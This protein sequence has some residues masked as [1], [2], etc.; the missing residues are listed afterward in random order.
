MT[1][2]MNID[3]TNNEIDEFG[4]TDLMLTADIEVVKMLVGKGCDM[5]VK[6]ESFNTALILSSSYI[7]DNISLFLIESGC[8]VNVQNNEGK[9]ALM[10]FT[11]RCSVNV[12]KALIARGCDVNMKDN[13]G[14]TAKIICLETRKDPMAALEGIMLVPGYEKFEKEYIKRFV[15][16]NDEI[17]HI[18]KAATK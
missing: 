14:K 2:S 11:E 7:N 9:T 6:N 4:N 16:D 3:M 12:V 18:L 17:Y 5:N 10:M 13:Y 8:D 15:K 1:N